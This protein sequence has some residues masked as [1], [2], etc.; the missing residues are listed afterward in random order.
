MEKFV[1][2]YKQLKLERAKTILEQ[3]EYLEILLLNE[4]E[5]LN[6]IMAIKTLFGQVV[7]LTKEFIDKKTK[8][9]YNENKEASSNE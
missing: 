4:A 3:V 9:I 2:E 6:Q 1:E 5:S 7:N 8:E